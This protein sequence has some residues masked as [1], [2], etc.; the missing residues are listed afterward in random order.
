MKDFFRKLA[1]IEKEG[2]RAALAIVVSTKGSTPRKAGTKMIIMED[3]STFG[4]LGGGGL[5]KKVIEESLEALK[6]GEARL[7]SFNLDG[8]KGNLDMMCGGEIEIYIEPIHQPEK[9]IIFGAGHITKALAPLMQS[10]GFRLTVV[11]DN[12]EVLGEDQLADMEGLISENMESYAERL[13][14]ESNTYIVLLTRGFS[15]DRAILEHLIGKDFRYVGMIGS[16]KKIRTIKE[17]LISK[18]IEKEYFSKL[19][20]PIG[21]DIG[22]ETPEEIALSIAA[23]IISVRK[24]KSMYRGKG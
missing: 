3:G 10:V 5:E 24:G 18:G 13:P 4:T 19:Y 14:P 21:L 9:L 12:P 2:R 20:A 1:D 11:E 23:E 22:A 17:E 6:G 16:R 8:T 7:T 15:T